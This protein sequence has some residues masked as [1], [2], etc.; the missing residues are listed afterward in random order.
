VTACGSDGCEQ[1]DADER[2]SM[3]RFA[4]S[5]RGS[6]SF[7]STSMSSAAAASPRQGDEI[8]GLERSPQPALLYKEVKSGSVSMSWRCVCCARGPG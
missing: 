8:V 7:Y 3:V 1:L 6:E 4:M 2:C 5:D